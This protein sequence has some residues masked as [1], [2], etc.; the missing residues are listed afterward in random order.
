PIS[1][2][3]LFAY[4]W[5]FRTV[6]L[7]QAPHAPN[8]NWSDSN[9]H[10]TIN[11]A[12]STNPIPVQVIT[13]LKWTPYRYNAT[14][15]DAGWE[16]FD[17]ADYWF[18]LE[19]RYE[20][21]LFAE[22]PD[23]AVA[24]GVL[25]TVQL[26]YYTLFEGLQTVVQ[27]GDEV[28]QDIPQPDEAVG[29]VVEVGGY[30]VDFIRSQVISFRA[31][32]ESQ[33][34]FFKTI[35]AGFRAYLDNK[36][37]SNPAARAFIK[38]KD[39]LTGTQRIKLYGALFLA[40][41]AFLVT[42]VSLTLAGNTAVLLTTLGILLLIQIAQFAFEAFTLIRL[43]INTFRQASTVRSALNSISSATSLS[44]ASLI[45]AIVGIIVELG[46]IWG[47][48]IYALASNTV[49]AGSPGFDALLTYS[50]AASLVGLLLFAIGL[51][52]VVGAIIVGILA[53][54][55]GLLT[56]IC[57]A[58]VDELRGEND[59]CFTLTG[60]LT[61]FLADLFYSTDIIFDF[62]S[63]YVQR[64]R[65]P[66]LIDFSLQLRDERLGLVAGNAVKFRARLTGEIGPSLP[67]DAAKDAYSKETIR[68]TGLEATL[69]TV[70]QSLAAESGNLRHA[71]WRFRFI[72][73][74]AIQYI[75][76]PRVEW[77]LYAT[78]IP[79][80][81]MSTNYVPLNEPGVNA[82]Y[83]TPIYLNVGLDMPQ[84]SCTF[85]VCSADDYYASDFSEEVLTSS[86]FALDILPDN[87]S[88][89]Y[90][91]NWGGFP[92]DADA[93]N[94][95][96]TNYRSWP[97]LAIQGVDPGPDNP[98][99]DNDGLPDGY[100]LLLAAE[101][102][103]NPAL[104][105]ADTDGDGLCDGDEVRLG[106]RADRAD[107][108]GDGL[109]DGEEVWHQVCGSAPTNWTGGWLFTY[110]VT[111][112]LTMRATS[113]PLLADTDG[114]GLTDLGE[115]RLH[116]TNPALYPYH[117]QVANPLPLALYQRVDDVD[118]Y[119]RLDQSVVYTST[120]VNRFNEPYYLNGTLTTAFPPALG[121]GTVAHPF[122]L[123][124]GE[125]QTWT[126]NRTAVGQQTEN[127]LIEDT[128]TA[129]FAP[130]AQNPNSN[131]PPDLAYNQ[132]FPLTLDNDRPT[133]TLTSGT[134]IQAGGFRV[135]GG[136]AVDPT[137]YVTQVEI[138]IPGDDTWHPATGA[139]A[140]AYTWAVPETAGRYTLRSRATDAVGLLEAPAHSF[141]LIADAQPPTFTFDQI[142]NPI[143]PAQ[144]DASRRWAVTLSGTAADPD[145]L[146]D[147]GSGVQTV[148]VRL[149]PRTT[150]WQPALYDPD[151]S[152]WS[153]DYPI[154]PY[155]AENQFQP[156]ATGTYT[157][158]LRALD[159]VDNI[160]PEEAYQT[161]TIRIDN[162]PPRIT[163][164]SLGQT[165]G[166][167]VNRVT[168]IT[169]SL[170][171]TGT[172]TDPDIVS[173]GLQGAEIA[174]VPADLLDTLESPSLL[175]YLNEPQGVSV[176][177]DASGQQN[178]A[179]CAPETCPTNDVPGIYGGAVQMSAG[180][181]L[182]TAVS[183]PL[184]NLS[185]S[186]WFNTSD[187]ESGLFTTAVGGTLD[188]TADRALY[189]VNGNLCALVQN[190]TT[191]NEIC[192]TGT[193][194]ADG[195]WHQ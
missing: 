182:S 160:T 53:I 64:N 15:D 99:V 90:A 19:R 104:N 166:L 138:Q 115:K 124:P 91:R 191:Q 106:T 72:G 173:G 43:T 158:T 123:F 4:E 60:A 163:L 122:S 144:R 24:E 156:Y 66:Q 65:F 54:V 62:D 45:L 56:L 164:D 152:Q 10:L 21:R 81:A 55:D 23:P 50:I 47:Y 12:E 83:M 61:D 177:R 20:A 79:T 63:P 77:P 103:F 128:A 95:G 86:N 92:F 11:L 125:S 134:Y 154:D 136:T 132:A 148:E 157:V 8:F 58:G 78:T 150:G 44:K 107:T 170:T 3:L 7:D 22:E 18:E 87:L 76:A 2:T 26:Y 176:Y 133:S 194:Y 165:D 110:N 127:L 114:D 192:S 9:S 116:E 120:A 29:I 27:V 151:T 32:I 89:F 129:V 70:S 82:T 84:Y 186:L 195:A 135:M 109:T 112:T 162:T 190:G 30:V 179:T 94:D 68:T 37:E 155:D 36:I 28:S 97:D 180:E 143:L 102:P 49:A 178:E 52:P 184:D 119:V 140:W 96:A 189:L 183:L 6:N 175:L 59:S 14:P 57:E 39:S 131:V 75:P 105:R 51:I 121:D 126:T 172:I 108:D 98:D 169:R 1:P 25:L 31:Q 88:D 80:L 142:G 35:A 118:G 48:F 139:E 149:E 100:E 185:I 74:A 46:I 145:V 69:S 71:N 153:L 146:T 171:L 141:T 137:S 85:N 188:D 167:T 67:Q 181:Y 159:N 174:F 147:P 73:N 40:I 93:D 38:Y 161:Y 187:P 101:T 113:N 41:S 34:T 16:T 168:E 17:I 117:P 13:S 42:L 111:D 5:Q 130:T 193:N 33:E